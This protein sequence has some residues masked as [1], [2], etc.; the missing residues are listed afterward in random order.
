MGHDLR[1][2]GEL[3]WGPRYTIAEAA[4][5][6]QV[7][8]KTI[9]YALGR[10]DMPGVISS[11]AGGLSFANLLELHV[12]RALRRQGLSLQNIRL[13]V[14]HMYSQGMLHPLLNPTLRHDGRSLFYEV[15][16]QVINASKH[17]QGELRELIEAHLAAIEWS[18]E[19]V[20]LYPSWAPQ[21]IVSL[22]PAI[23]GGAPVLHGTRL[24]IPFLV[25]R[26]EAGASFADLAKE[27]HVGR[28]PLQHAIEAFQQVSR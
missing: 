13:A 5:H 23:A 3:L 25:R 27:Y 10:G 21:R 6:V 19:S 8:P 24:N 16:A 14:A 12:V 1:R 7:A 9:R 2:Y 28:A 11:P 20:R 22:D 17:G 18:Q 26:H 4:L 15:L